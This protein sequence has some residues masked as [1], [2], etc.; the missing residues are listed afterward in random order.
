MAN[1]MNFYY[2]PSGEKIN[3]QF[4]QK[5]QKT[6]CLTHFGQFWGQ[7]TSFLTNLTF[8]NL[9]KTN[10]PI[11]SCSN[12]QKDEKKDGKTLF[13]SSGYCWWFNKSDIL[14]KL[15]FSGVKS[16]SMVHKNFHFSFKFEP[17]KNAGK[18]KLV[19]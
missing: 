18:S 2:R 11:L 6:L 8:Q 14:S 15:K 19:I 1:K 4:F 9:G 5:P 10:Y 12:G 13:Y 3:D 16:L 17:L 7:K